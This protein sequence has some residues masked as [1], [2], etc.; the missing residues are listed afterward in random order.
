MER[1][2]WIAAAALAWGAAHAQTRLEERYG[3]E[4]ASPPPPAPANPFALP[5]PGAQQRLTYQ[6]AIGS[7]SEV[8]YR[9]DQDLNHAA[10]DNSLIVIPQVNG[11]V[12][13]RPTDW[14]ETT[15]EANIEREIPVH[16]ERQV[17]LPDGTVV[18]P[19]KR[20]TQAPVMQ[21]FV[22][23]RRP[24]DPFGL[25]V[26]R[27][28]YED[29]RHWLYDTSMDM[30]AVLFRAGAFRA[31]ASAG[32]EVWKD[33]D[34]APESRQVKDRV[35]TYMLYGEYRGFDTMRFA[36]YSIMRDDRQLLEGRV[37]QTGLRVLGLPVGALSYWGEVAFTSGHD[38]INQRMRGYAGDVGA[39]YR[40]NSLPLRPHITLGYAMGSG[41]SDDR[42]RINR[43]FR[44]TGLQTNEARFGGV[45]MFKYYGEV[46]DME[47]SN[48]KLG[49]AGIGLRPT[50]GVSVDLVYHHYRLHR[51]IDEN[52]NWGLTALMN[53]VN[54]RD[55]KEVGAALDLVIGWRNVFGIRRLGV[56]VRMGWFVPGKAF[57]RNDGTRA[58]PDLRDADDAA[59]VVMKIFL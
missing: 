19:Q 26:G 22:T 16:E 47:L 44:Q 5:T 31:E 17:R 52:R 7:E 18:T 24:G 3:G 30:V 10:R 25:S 14:L 12:T 6:Y 41:D 50:S 34:L 27:R 48:I 11:I 46:M 53:Q 15:F 28:N 38:E 49:T 45:G 1:I 4:L 42:D 54:G 20:H 13:W 43:E 23:L 36:G 55:S 33:M 37:I 56:D 32:R 35:N 21:A 29:D 57:L 9:R 39:T 2:A 40:F 58:R 59:A 8:L 51:I